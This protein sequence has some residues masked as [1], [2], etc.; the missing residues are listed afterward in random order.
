MNWRKKMNVKRAMGFFT[1][2]SKVI[3]SRR[4]YDVEHYLR[5]LITHYATRLRKAYATKDFEQL[6]RIDEQL[7]FFD[8]PVEHIEPIWIRSQYKV[9]TKYA[10]SSIQY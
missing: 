4:D 5:V 9:E 8:R 3:K 6:F 7:G 1:L 10:I 2:N